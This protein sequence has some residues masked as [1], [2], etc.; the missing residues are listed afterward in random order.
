VLARATRWRHGGD[1]QPDRE[2]RAGQVVTASFGLLRRRARLLWPIGLTL[3]LATAGALGLQRL[4]LHRRPTDDLTDVYGIADNPLGIVLAVLISALLAPVVAVALAATCRSVEGIARSHPVTGWGAL[5]LAVRRP[6][7][8]ITQL[9]LFAAVTL[10]ASSLWLLPLAVLLISFYAVAMP[11]AVI[12]D[13]GVRAAFHRSRVLTKGRRWRALLLSV[14]L[15]W[16]GF[17][18]PGVVGGVLLLLTGWPF[19]ITNV[20]SILVGAV[21]LPASAIGLTLQFYDFRQEE[22]RNQNSRA[23]TS[24]TPRSAS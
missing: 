4:V 18:L 7:G 21:L 17:S 5:A 2:R 19:W 11:A 3:G 12:E 22:A 8:A 24:S 1:T 13:L 16:I 15:V 9:L 14:I 6:S 23:S 20:V 10:L